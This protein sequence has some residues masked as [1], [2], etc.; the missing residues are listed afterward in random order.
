MRANQEL[1]IAELRN[2]SAV[3][4]QS[5]RWP[6][7]H[8]TVVVRLDRT[9]R[10]VAASRM[11]TTVSGYWACR[12]SRAMTD[13][14]FGACMRNLH[15][16][17]RIL[18]RRALSNTASRSRGW[19]RPSF[20]LN[21][22]TLQ[23]EGAGNAGRPMRPIAACATIVVVSTRVV[24]SHRNHPA[25]PTQWFYGF[26]RALPGDRLSCHRHQRKLPSANLTPAPG[27]Q[28]NTTSPSAGRIARQARSPRP[29]HP[30]PRFVTLRNAPP[31]E[32]DGESY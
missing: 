26:L 9:I 18:I 19:K 32:R 31:K 24:R 7:L 20:A 14:G 23:S 4:Q 8:S 22:F 30:A 2:S 27:R 12:S 5:D 10:Y 16:T 6:R 21:F 17:S 3:R 28:D 13:G 29:P 11:N 1:A 25:F 15:S